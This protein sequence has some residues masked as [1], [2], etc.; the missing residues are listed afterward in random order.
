LDLTT[1]F[2]GYVNKQLPILLDISY[3]AGYKVKITYIQQK[4]DILTSFNQ[5]KIND[6]P[7]GIDIP[8][9]SVTTE[10]AST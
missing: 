3:Y 10:L 7:I 2:G 1:S 8:D 5:V 4:V 6:A 9:F